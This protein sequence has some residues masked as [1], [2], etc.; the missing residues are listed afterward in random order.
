M[1]V[2]MAELRRQNQILE[3]NV[4]NIQQR[5]QETGILEEMEVVDPLSLLDEIWVA[6]IPEGFKPPYLGKFDGYNDLY[7]HVSSIN[8]QMAIIG[9]SN[10]LKCKLLYSTFRVAA[11]RW[12][13]GL[14]QAFIDSY[15]EQVKKM[16]HQFATIFHRKMSTTILFNIR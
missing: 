11:F 3:D 12:Y 14:P 8:T 10:A 2:V 5:Q 15:Q 1:H 9:V 7:A 6:P 13:L 4:L 16:A